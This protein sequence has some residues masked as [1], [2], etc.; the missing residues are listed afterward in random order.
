MGSTFDAYEDK[1][2]KKISSS[3]PKHIDRQA[4]LNMGVSEQDA[5]RLLKEQECSGDGSGD[6]GEGDSGG[7]LQADFL[8]SAK[9]LTFEQGKNLRKHKGANSQAEKTFQKETIPGGAFV[10]KIITYFKKPNNVITKQIRVPGIVPNSFKEYEKTVDQDGNTIRL[11][12][13]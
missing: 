7:S 1:E 13:G 10:K 3:L 11:K 9:P 2:E 8:D 12:D 5:S 6:G 4:L